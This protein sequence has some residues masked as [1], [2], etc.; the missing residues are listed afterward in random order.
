MAQAIYELGLIL[1]EVR[2]IAVYNFEGQPHLQD[3]LRY[4]MCDKALADICMHLGYGTDYSK[5]DRA[6]V[7]DLTIVMICLT[8][9]LSDKRAFET[10]IRQVFGGHLDD[11]NFKARVHLSFDR[12]IRSRGIETWKSKSARRARTGRRI[13]QR[14]R[15]VPRYMP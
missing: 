15:S 1:P 14:G 10:R 6:V 3:E 12:C 11:Q 8:V 5:T 13:G 2:R 7:M 9:G 4:V